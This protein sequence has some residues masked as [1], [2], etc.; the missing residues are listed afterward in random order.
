MSEYQVIAIHTIH[1]INQVKKLVSSM[2]DAAL[3]RTA[4]RLTV[5]YDI[6]DYEVALIICY[7]VFYC[8]GTHGNRR[9][10]E[11]IPQLFLL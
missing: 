4:C 2:F 7:Q 5:Q 10:K 11:Q 9:I 8:T 1:A 6:G 3:A